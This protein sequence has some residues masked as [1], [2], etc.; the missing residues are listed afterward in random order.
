MPNIEVLN[1][2]VTLVRELGPAAIKE[3]CILKEAHAA[4]YQIKDYWNSKDFQTFLEAYTVLAV[5][6]GAEI[7]DN[8]LYTAYLLWSNKFLHASLAVQ[9]GDINSKEFRDD[10][11][12]MGAYLDNIISGTE[13]LEN[14][15][16]KSS[17]IS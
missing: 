7:K 13:V 9:R 17:G 2:L 16:R 4:W 11:A 12:A 3:P 6:Y 10:F 8:A 1:G 15:K 14:W 5:L